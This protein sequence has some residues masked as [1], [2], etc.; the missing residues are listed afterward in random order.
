MRM[1]ALRCWRQVAMV[2]IVF[3]ASWVI[4]AVAQVQE[5]VDL[6][7]IYKIKEQG[8]QPQNSKVMELMSYSTDVYG[9]RLT[10]SPYRKAFSDW[11]VKTLTG[12]GL[13]DVHTEPVPDVGRGWVNDR[14]IAHAIMPSGQAFPLIGN[15]KA[16]TAG[17]NGL[18][19]GEAVRVDIQSEADFAK[20]AGKLK[21]KFAFTVNEFDVPAP[22][23]AFA[24]RHTD[25]D[26]KALSMQ[27]D[28]APA[29]P[30]GAPQRPGGERTPGFA[31]KLA[32]FWTAEGVACL[33]DTSFGS[34]GTTRVGSGGGR[35]PK[36]PVSVCQV[37]LTPEH[38]NRIVRTLAKNLPVTIEMDVRSRF[39][40]EPG[41][42]YN[43][44]GDIRGTD[45]ADE[46]VMLGGHWDSWHGGTGAADNAAGFVTMMEAVRILKASGLPLRRSVRI[47]LWDAEEQGLLGSRAYVKEHFA[48]RE[49]MALKPDHAKFQAYFNIDNGTGVARG[50]YL[51]GN[52]SIAPVFGAW[53]E[54]LRSMGMTTLSIRN[55]G[56]TDHLSFDAVGLPG[57]QFIQDP[58]EYGRTYHTNMDN[59]ERIR[60]SDMM[61]NAVI[62]ATF[63]YQAA[64]RDQLLP[65]KPLPKPQ[66][67][68]PRRPM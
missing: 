44:L 7:A 38:Y 68:T 34:G 21:G 67:A 4:P 51:Q 56:G 2:A 50:V 30:Q 26:L 17:T 45:K 13:V 39:A 23:M 18:V 25:D 22:F 47:A 61:Q 53:M 35:D 37:S 49:T 32:A 40:D 31:Q 66:P 3:G 9:P 55:T 42:V 62:L 20:Y 36:G 58:I 27:P 41:L 19:T 54:P 5:K 59:Y 48:D 63:V 57:F 12:W 14:F 64:N 6:D 43:I 29:R 15:P 10:G 46:V 24:R 11:A 65:R 8:L 1:C 33:V 52:E 28:P 16:W 60:P